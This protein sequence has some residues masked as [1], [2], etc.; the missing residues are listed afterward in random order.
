MCTEFLLAII[1][2]ITIL[3]VNYFLFKLLRNYFINILYLTKIKNIFQL[4]NPNTNKIISFFY[5]IEKNKIFNNKKLF[6]FK[7]LL[8]QENF[9]TKSDLL[10]IG[11]IYKKL[12]QLT[13]NNSLKVKGNEFFF[14]LLEKQY[15]SEKFNIK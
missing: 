11:N 14:N 8:E 4:Y 15:L 5:S 3:T 1:Y 6:N 2:F 7:I 9:S 10:V 13:K 12:L